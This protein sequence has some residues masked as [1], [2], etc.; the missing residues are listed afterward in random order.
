MK[1]ASNNEIDLLLRALGRRGQS[2]ARDATRSDGDN[3]NISNHLDADELSSYAE[4]VV[5]G[6]ARERYTQHLAE[7]DR[8]RGIVITLSQSAGATVRHDVVKHQTGSSFWSTLAVIF[9]PAV[10]RYAVPALVVTA[11]IG[12]GLL[13]LRQRDGTSLVARN[14][15]VA[16]APSVESKVLPPTQ[17]SSGFADVQPSPTAPSGISVYD[18]ETKNRQVLA[19]DKTSATKAPS[20]VGS[21]AKSG[22]DQPPAVAEDAGAA[23]PKY[24]PEPQ[25]PP[26]EPGFSN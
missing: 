14:E 20:E 4:G 6:P 8:C 15:G 3:G 18:S 26:A 13:V 23:Q 11:M 24:A 7:C 5:T 1:Q 17:P 16:P 9:S 25:A 12:I 22:S 2:S 21:I 10:L 19:D